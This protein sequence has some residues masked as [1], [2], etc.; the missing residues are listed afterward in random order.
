MA[1][2]VLP[3]HFFKGCRHYWTHGGTL[4]HI[5][6]DDG[7]RKNNKCSR[8]LSSTPTVIVTVT[9]SSSASSA[10][11]DPTL[12]APLAA[13]T[14]HANPVGVCGNWDFE[15]FRREIKDSKEAGMWY[16]EWRWYLR[17]GLE[18]F[19]GMRIFEEVGILGLGLVV[20]GWG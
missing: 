16:L 14:I 9:S 13:T 10:V 3:R 12:L 18:G 20:I 8:T 11:Q 5:P 6:D 2:A 1:A 17:A 7:I 15:L 4:R 19:G